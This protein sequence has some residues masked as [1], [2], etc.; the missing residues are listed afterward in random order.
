MRNY[1][2]EFDQ[3]VVLRLRLKLNELLFLDYVAKFINSGNM[4][5]K[6][7][8]GKRYYRLTYKKILEDLPVLKIKERQLRNLIASLEEKGVLERY[9]ELKNEMHLYVDFDV[10]FGKK[11]PAKFNLSEI[12]YH[13]AGNGVLTIDYYDIKKI[14]IIHD[15]A[16]V[17]ELDK[18]E[19]FNNLLANLKIH[20]GEILYDGFIKD[21]LDI[22]EITSKEIIFDIGNV[23][24]V[25]QTYA[26]RF[27][28]AFDNTLKAFLG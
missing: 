2:F 10:L 19:F 26:Q 22:D 25:G 9:A 17:K 28:D 16:R 13:D 20:Y 21:K 7:L 18:D 23:K 24:L 12:G 4:R 8:S 27:K 5:Y 3:E 1:I 14:K 15:N 6:F 11:L